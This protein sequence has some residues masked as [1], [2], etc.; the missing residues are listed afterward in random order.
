LC[1]DGL[2]ERL[3]H[4]ENKKDPEEE[5]EEELE[6]DSVADILIYMLSKKSFILWKK[7]FTVMEPV[8]EDD[9]GE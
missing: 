1:V 6:D 5:L 9:D 8:G 2:L 7:R 4:M 3:N